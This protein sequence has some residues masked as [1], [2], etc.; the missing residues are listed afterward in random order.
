LDHGAF[1]GD[2]FRSANIADELLD[3]V[4]SR[5]SNVAGSSSG[6][7]R[8]VRELISAVARTSVQTKI[9][10]TNEYVS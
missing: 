10:E 1:V 6:P 7:G 2:G 3:W 9:Q 5:V 8:S 4:Q